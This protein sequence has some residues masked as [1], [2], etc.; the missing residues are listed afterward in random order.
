MYQTCSEDG[1]DVETSMMERFFPFLCN[2][3]KISGDMNTTMIF[4]LLASIHLSWL[5][6][7]CFVDVLMRFMHNSLNA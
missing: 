4:F 6:L 1:R 3:S 2:D 7:V 5:L